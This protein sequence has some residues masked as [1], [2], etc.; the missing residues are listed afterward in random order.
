M[1]KRVNKFNSE[2]NEEDVNSDTGENAIPLFSDKAIITNSISLQP[3]EEY[4]NDVYVEMPESY[5]RPTREIV[6]E[7]IKLHEDVITPKKGTSRSCCHDVYTC[8]HTEKVLIKTR[9]LDTFE[10]DVL[11]FPEIKKKGIFLDS[12]ETAKIPTGILFNIPDGYKMLLY[13][14]SGMSLNKYL[15]LRN[16]VGVID[17]DYVEELFVLIVNMSE[18]R[19][20]ISH[21]EPIAQ[22]SLE[23]VINFDLNE[24]ES[25]DKFFQRKTERIGGFGHT[26]NNR[27]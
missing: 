23:K 7:M 26:D 8:F 10:R 17:E 18:K 15:V 6:L 4:V 9:L 27:S 13:P 11:Y 2:T 12:L 14:R 25:N 20:I 19:V 1:R 5:L 3:N 21:Q 22:F 16:N 24:I